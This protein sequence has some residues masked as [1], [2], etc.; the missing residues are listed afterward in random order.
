MPS[1]AHAATRPGDRWRAR[2][3]SE[4]TAGVV[5]R[6]GP[7]E[8][9]LW[10]LLAARVG[11]WVCRTC[12]N[13]TVR[14][15]QMARVVANLRRYGWDLPEATRAACPTHGSVHHDRLESRELSGVARGRVDYSPAE[16]LRIQRICGDEDAF[17]G[18]R[19]QLQ[20]DHR[21]PQ[22]R[23]PGPEQRV[24]LEDENAVRAAFQCLSRQ[25]NLLKS[26]A[27]EACVK[28]GQR[29]VFLG[30]PV[31]FRGEAAYDASIGCDGCGWAF[32]EEWKSHVGERL[33]SAGVEPSAAGSAELDPQLGDT[34]LA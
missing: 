18:G 17:T 20:V 21:V 12:T 30:I 10:E 9:Q 34:N 22:V 23:W 32:P 28:T 3:L 14:S 16:K 5:D 19:E 33:A 11:T 29:P 8:L 24:D 1:P 4:E 25:H 13:A 7:K 27:C 6:L 31:W 2:G 26:R 15:N